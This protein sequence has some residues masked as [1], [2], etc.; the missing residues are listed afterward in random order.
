MKTCDR[1]VLSLGSDPH[2]DIVYLDEDAFPLPVGMRNAE[3]AIFDQLPAG[4]TPG[5]KRG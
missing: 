3:E 5:C 4:R 2:G 1:T